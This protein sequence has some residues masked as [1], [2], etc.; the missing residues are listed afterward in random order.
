MQFEF[1]NKRA[2]LTYS[3]KV[4]KC[5]YIW[6]T[7]WDESCSNVKNAKNVKSFDTYC[8]LSSNKVSVRFI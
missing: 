8:I 1:S 4:L 3:T 2:Q 7:Q 6:L 5:V